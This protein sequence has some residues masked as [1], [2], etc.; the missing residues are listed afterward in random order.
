MKILF[1][2]DSAIMRRSMIKTATESGYKTVE[3][4]NGAEALARLLKYGNSIDLII[5]DWNM[6]VMDGYETL[7]KIKGH[8][9]Y[10]RIPVLMATADGAEEDVIKA[11]KAGAAGYLVKPFSPEDLVDK[12]KSLARS[13]FAHRP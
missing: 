3:A 9:D 5:M 1:V 11:I 13:G 6:P 12:I 4:V 2:E 8:D 10:A 7:V